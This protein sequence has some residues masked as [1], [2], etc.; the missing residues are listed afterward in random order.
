VLP[1]AERARIVQWVNPERWSAPIDAIVI[2]DFLLFK[3]KAL[4]QVGSRFEAVKVIERIFVYAEQMGVA[5][6]IVMQLPAMR[7]SAK[8]I[9]DEHKPIINRSRHLVAAYQHLRY[10][11]FAQKHKRG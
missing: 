11:I 1:F 9:P 5:D 6:K 4:D 2:E 10:Y 8:G 3:D 7:L